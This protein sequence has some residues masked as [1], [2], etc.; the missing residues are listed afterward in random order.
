MVF[1]IYQI[2]N[3]RKSLTA[4]IPLFV[5]LTECLLVAILQNVLSTQKPSNNFTIIKHPLWGFWWMIAVY[6]LNLRLNIFKNTKIQGFDAKLT[7]CRCTTF[8]SCPIFL[9]ILSARVC[10]CTGRTA[11]IGAAL[12]ADAAGSDCYYIWEITDTVKNGSRFLGVR[13]AKKR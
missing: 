1:K 7:G 13:L 9:L 11:T 8:P 2:I 3:T 6:L 5:H 10:S 4:F 12:F